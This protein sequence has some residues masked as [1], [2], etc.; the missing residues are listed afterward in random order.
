MT[1]AQVT[2]CFLPAQHL[3]LHKVSLFTLFYLRLSDLSQGVI[4]LRD[5]VE[6]FHVDLVQPLS[7]QDQAVS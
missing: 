5:A 7:K 6:V 3:K 4:P 2:S 1:P